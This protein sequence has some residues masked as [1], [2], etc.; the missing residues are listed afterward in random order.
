MSRIPIHTI[1]NAP[2]ASRTWLEGVIRVSPTGRLLNLHAQMAHSPAVLSAYMSIRQATAQHATLDDRV[3]SAVM[4][5]AAGAS[6]SDYAAAITSALA[7]RAGWTHEQAG[8]LRDGR[9][10]GD[11]KVDSLVAVVREAASAAGHVDDA[12]WQRATQSGW[13]S[14]HLAETF[15][16]LGLAVFTAYFVN[17]AQ[18]PDDLAA[19]A[20][21]GGE[22]QR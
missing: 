13:G 6:H 8:A 21:A 3:R 9:S 4:L 15:A 16:F 5:A 22:G 20:P 2:S 11:D 14:E 1:K 12:T 17:Y 19:A 18:T 10:V 7:L